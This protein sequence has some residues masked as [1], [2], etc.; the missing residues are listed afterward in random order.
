MNKEKVLIVGKI[1]IF[2]LNILCY[3]FSVMS[4]PFKGFIGFN[5]IEMTAS[6]FVMLVSGIIIIIDIE[7]SVINKNKNVRKFFLKLFI[8]EIICFILF[9]CLNGAYYNYY[10]SH[11][12]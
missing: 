2:C 3:V 11:Y 1:I 10:I 7:I 9:R 5:G 4:N 8:I 12:K 6:F